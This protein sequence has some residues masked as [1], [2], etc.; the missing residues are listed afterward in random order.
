MSQRLGSTPL[1]VMGEVLSQGFFEVLSACGVPP[2]LFAKMGATGQRE[3]YR[4]FVALTVTPLGRLLEVGVVGQV[5]GRYQARLCWPVYSRLE[6][7]G[8]GVSFHG[9]RLDGRCKGCGV[10]GVDGGGVS[11]F[12]IALMITAFPFL[13]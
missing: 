3:S 9:W 7:P 10:G 2:G 6:R 4:R 8:A 5:G 12:V 11:L 13:R 1:A